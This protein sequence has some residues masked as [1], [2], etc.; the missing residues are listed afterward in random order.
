M[1]FSISH[2]SFELSE[3]YEA[4]G[5]L[6]LGEAQALNALRAENI[7][8]MVR[9]SFA[10]YIAQHGD[11]E[12][13]LSP[14]GILDFQREVETIDSLYQFKARVTKPRPRNGTLEAEIRLVA[15]E[16]VGSLVRA[17]GLDLSP[18]MFDAQVRGFSVREDI[19]AE[20]RRRLSARLK[21]TR[22]SI[23]DILGA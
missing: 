15:E 22:E 1:H 11:A 18:S 10:G 9:R 6:T 19:Q 5:V 14:E 12:G 7:R 20:A 3:P 2:Y 13:L 8:E 21:A 16:A 17:R 23:D 4:G